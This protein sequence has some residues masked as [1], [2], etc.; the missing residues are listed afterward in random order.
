[1]IAVCLSG[2][3]GVL[4]FFAGQE[5]VESLRDGAFKPFLSLGQ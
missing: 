1:M 2:G 3:L 5:V 4:T